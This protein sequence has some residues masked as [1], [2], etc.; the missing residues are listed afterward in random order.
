MSTQRNDDAWS[1]KVTQVVRSHVDGAVGHV[2][3]DRPKA[4]NAI[5]VDLGAQLERA[6]TEVAS[7]ARVILIR[8]AGGNFSVGGDFKELQ[9]L[10]AAGPGAMAPLFDNFGRAC[11]LIATLPVPV[12][13]V[14][15]GYA[16]A[17]GFELMQSCD[18]VLVHEAARISDTHANFGQVPGGGS[19]QRLPRLVGRQRALAHILTGE[20]LSGAEAVAWG[21]AYRCLPDDGFEEAVAAFAEGL[22]GK[23]PQALATAKRLVYE[24]LRLPLADGLARERAAVLDHL[25]GTAAGA[26]IAAFTGER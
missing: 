4:M 25:G 8:G 1:C 16:M 5:T 24:G 6:L 10:R 2:V 18:I 7:A 21:L 11:A 19:T 17:G 14:V 3:L 26:A 20:R 13:A 15:E 23:D 9:R 12:V 22:A